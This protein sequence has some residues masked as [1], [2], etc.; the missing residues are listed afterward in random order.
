MGLVIGAVVGAILGIVFGLI[1]LCLRLWTLRQV[2]RDQA[3]RGQ[4]SQERQ[5]LNGPAVAHAVVPVEGIPTTPS[6]SYEH[7]GYPTPAGGVQPSTADKLY[8]AA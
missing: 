5:P 4:G 1:S 8:G 3:A 6:G 7:A 2:R